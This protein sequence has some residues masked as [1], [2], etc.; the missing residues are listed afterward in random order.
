MS[1]DQLR[2]E[3]KM[4]KIMRVVRQ[5][6]EKVCVIITIILVYENALV[7]YQHLFPYWWSHGFYLRFFVNLI[8]GHWLLINTVVHYYL[9]ISTYPGFVADLKKEL[10][11]EEELVYTKC[12]K[13]GVMRPP[14]AHHCKVCQKCVFRYDHHCKCV[15]VNNCFMRKKMKYK[16]MNHFKS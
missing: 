14:R 7:F 2:S 9:A 16:K 15:K 10:T 3:K 12:S 13:C 5:I 1:S 6:V 4:T 8:I 11:I